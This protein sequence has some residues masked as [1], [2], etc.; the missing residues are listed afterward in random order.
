MRYVTTKETPPARFTSKAE[1]TFFLLKGATPLCKIILTGF[2]K[3][4]LPSA[5]L[6]KLSTE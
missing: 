4:K 5:S 2:Q 1:D 3:V 6:C